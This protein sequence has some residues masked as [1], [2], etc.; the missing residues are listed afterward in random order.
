[1][2]T[3]SAIER[4]NRI[5]AQYGGDVQTTAGANSSRPSAIPNTQSRTAQ[6]A[7]PVTQ[8]ITQSSTPRAATQTALARAEAIY[9]RYGERAAAARQQPVTNHSLQSSGA[10]DRGLTG[11]GSNTAAGTSRYLNS[12][13]DKAD[14]RAS[15]LPGSSYAEIL[16]RPDYAANSAAG[17][18]KVRWGFGSD[19]RYDY[20]NDIDGRRE[21]EDYAMVRAMG[22]GE[23]GKYAFMTQDE[24]G[25]YN[26]LYAT[27]GKQ[28]ANA[29]L[30]ELEPELNRQ[31]YSGASANAQELANENAA[32]KALYSG[33]TVLGQPARSLSSMLAAGQD[34]MNTI[35]GRGIDPYSKLR[36]PS[37]LTQD[38]REGIS[39]GMGKVESFLYNTGMSA[40]DSAMNY[41]ASRGLGKVFGLTGD[42]LM[43]ATNIIGSALMSSEVASTSVTE[44]KNKGYS[45]AG[46]LSLGLIRG[47]IEYLSEAIGGEWV[48]KN[49]KSNPLNLFSTMLLGMIPEGMEEVMSDAGNEA[50]NIIIDLLF[51]TDESYIANSL[52]YFTEQGDKDPVGSTLK[53]IVQHELLS[54]LGGA[55]A[56]VGSSGVQYGTNRAAINQ[57]AEQLHTTPET[58]VTLMQEL[59]TDNPQLIG[60]LAEMHDAENAEDFRKKVGEAKN[61]EEAIDAAMK[62]KGS[63]SAFDENVTDAELTQ[64]R[65]LAGQALNTLNLDEQTRA[66]LRVLQTAA[67]AELR[68]RGAN[69]KNAA[70]DNG[71]EQRAAEGVGPYANNTANNANNTANNANNITGRGAA[72]NM[73]GGENHVQ[74]EAETEGVLGQAQT[75]PPT[76]EEAGRGGAP[77]AAAAGS[78][79]GIETAQSGGAG[80]EAARPAGDRAGWERVSDAGGGRDAGESSGGE[81]GS[82]AERTGRHRERETM[83]RERAAAIRR[84]GNALRARGEARVVSSR[85]LGIANGTD[86]QDLTVIDEAHYNERLRKLDEQVRRESGYDDVV[87]VI[88][89]IHTVNGGKARGAITGSRIIIQLDHSRVPAENI[90]EHEVFHAKAR[91]DPGLVEAARQ[92]IIERFTPEEF[93]R[94]LDSYID[95]L[96]GSVLDFDESTDPEHIQELAELVIEE[97]TADAYADINYFGLGADRYG[98]DVRKTVE[99]RAA[100]QEQNRGGK[101]ETRGPPTVQHNVNNDFGNDNTKFSD[102]DTE[103]DLVPWDTSPLPPLPGANYK[104]ETATPDRLA[105]DQS[106]NVALTAS[107]DSINANS[108]DGNTKFSTDDSASEG[109]E[110]GDN[111][112]SDRELLLTAASRENAGQDLTAYARKNGRIETLE[113]KLTRLQEAMESADEEE[114]PQLEAMAAKAEK[115]LNRAKDDLAKM[116][117]N[118]VLKQTLDRERTAWREENPT[119]AARA[120]RTLREENAAM[121]ELVDYWKGQAKRTSDSDR[122]VMPEDTRRMARNLLREHSSE[123]STE[124]I[125]GKLQQLGNY[126]VSADNLDFNTIQKEARGIAREIVDNAYA[127]V[128][129]NADTREQ[130]RD[131]LRSTRLKIS[132][133][134]RGDV[135]D[136]ADFRRRNMGTLRLANEGRDIDSAYEELSGMFG[137][138]FFPKSITAH[139]DQLNQILDV[140]D[141]VQPSYEYM[142]SRY[143]RDEVIEHVTNEI[144]DGLIS[145]DVRQSK[146]YADRRYEHMARRNADLGERNQELNDR[147]RDER[148]NRRQL[149]QEKV[150]ELRQRSVDRDKSYRKR[151]AINKTVQRLSKFLTENSAKNHVPDNMKSM[152]GNLLLSIDTLSQRS[153]E[154]AQR[155]YL[156]RMNDVARVVAN[157]QKYMNGGEM[158][159]SMFL[160]LPH[161]LGDILSEHMT[162]IQDA[163]ENDRTWTTARMDLQ[164]LE[165]LDTI[166]NAVSK[167]VTTANELMASANNAKVSE[168]SEKTIAHLDDLG[169]AKTDN[170]A[171]RFLQFQNTTPYYFFK[172]FGEGGQL[173]FK[174]LQEG[175][176]KLGFNSKEVIDYAEKAYTGEECKKAESD[177]QEFKLHTRTLEEDGTENLRSEEAQTVRLTKAQIMELYTLSKRQQALGH[178]LGAGIRIGDIKDANGK[179][180]HQADNYLLTMEDLAAITGTLSTREK[181]IADT[182]QKHMNTKGSDWGNEVSMARFGVRQFTEENYW[183]IKTDSRSRAVRD[184]GADATNLFR[185]LNMSFTKSTVRDARNAVVIGSAFDTYA[186]HMADMAKYNALGLPMLDAMKWF[187][188]NTATDPNSQGQYTTTSVQKSTERAYGT[189]AQ[190]YF[191][192]FMK[193]MNG[194][195]EG[196]RDLEQFGSKMLSNYKVAAVGANLR[197]AMLQPTAY[198]RATAVLDPKYLVRGLAHNKQGRK[199]AMKYSGTAVWKDLGFYDTNI[200]NGLRAMI[201]HSDSAFEQIRE[202]SMILAKLGDKTTWGAIWNACK[203]QV[204]ETQHLEGEVLMKATAEL[205]DEVIY[206]TQVMDS[207]MTRSHSMRQ[208]GVYAGMTTAFMSEPTLSYNMVL[209]AYNEYQQE[210][211]KTGDVGKALNNAGSKLA[212]TMAVYAAT[213]AAASIVES[214]MDAWRDDDKYQ[215]RV[216]KWLE[217]EFG[218]GNLLDG[219]LM[220]DLLIHN[221]LPFIKEFDSLIN[222]Y[223][224]SRMDTEWMSNIVKT[225][226]I[227]RETLQLATGKLDKPTDITY[228]GKMTPWG[229]LY[230]TLK[231]A[232]Q[233]AGLPVGNAGREIVALYNN[234]IGMATGN[235]IS[236]YNP[237]AKNEVKY[238]VLDGWLSAEEAQRILTEEG[239]LE[240]E[241]KAETEVIK[242]T[243]QSRSE[244][245]TSTRAKAVQALTNSGA[246]STQEA[247]TTT[248]EIWDRIAALQPL[249]G[250][251]SVTKT[252]K[253]QTIAD[254]DI[255]VEQQLTMLG[256]LMEEDELLK[257]RTA[258]DY[259]VTPKVYFDAKVAMYNVSSDG[260][261]S[262][263]EAKQALDGQ[264]SLSN[265]ERAVIWQ[266]QN[267]TFKPKDNPYDTAIGSQVYDIITGKA[268]SK[269]GLELGS[270]GSGSSGAEAQS[271]AAA[272]NGLTLG[273][274]GQY[275]T[276]APAQDNNVAVN[277]GLT[278]GSW[279]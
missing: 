110:D 35:T 53:A 42:A 74:A 31:W 275:S 38:V 93:R 70:H 94:M 122:T 99:E 226:Q 90:A 87:F 105:N 168:V 98:E 17:D 279:G 39:K 262:K 112:P 229:K 236:T 156:R 106:L 79:T 173:I 11:T 166:L 274:W 25:V 119:E 182:L 264:R 137:E 144:I 36:Q 117:S 58:V 244:S 228:Y 142:Y 255:P 203:N 224:N 191:I 91:T 37:L 254:S 195:H 44:S 185:L 59:D 180:I 68:D 41:L 269:G 6:A 43:K 15:S 127:L 78:T 5:A 8:P 109:N 258:Y 13:Y 164:Q 207:T 21:K 196:G 118:P 64:L 77:D 260:Q 243:A 216:Q 76:G 167:A 209:D 242:W 138:G 199:E 103:N 129:E 176:G 194:T 214:L 218:D 200:N 276:G 63:R 108:E 100:L 257:T 149:V 278:L 130:L 261:I 179:T 66:Q 170:K 16:T 273:S 146:T 82:L 153:G 188:Y 89:A 20:I 141:H 123:A 135:T 131:Y 145:G 197:V 30:E 183:P 154:K 270:W 111:V 80:I 272:H 60:W 113:R 204:S 71:S 84:Y 157:Q 193:D 22:N 48:I 143:E 161:E 92:K 115:Q 251:A 121:R 34:L 239:I 177:V 55:F 205:F 51:N 151:V 215:S 72:V 136:M 3:Q 220:Q 61:A 83:Q 186:N 230:Q 73:T 27:Q 2:P 245:V 7:A 12:V 212:R 277:N 169:P 259:G 248:A 162:A 57:S 222:G 225:Y 256:A 126:L 210:L 231:T 65:D 75:V 107:D 265:K 52:Q 46:A 237:G 147:L 206:R 102:D 232:S 219:N 208:K 187:N 221:K 67:D 81:A 252:Q 23:L 47:G 9:A 192:Q 45:D 18:S 88:G 116:E 133:E 160:D 101:R 235:T 246:A 172:R 95:A 181:E 124:R 114:R 171:T 97:L 250:R 155:E 148:R 54:F 184:P 249:P 267:K 163:V 266:L 32:T 128:D 26:Y 271:S 33:L 69:H 50:A 40:G 132:D 49:V 240:D 238:A 217:A 234:T 134:L 125:A 233:M 139:A 86:A 19:T 211:R 247:F 28:A 201:K 223:S 174:N 62:V 263:A 227:W 202:K 241:A 253:Y 152:V 175:W 198:V 14:S 165:E 10:I 85:E 268:E 213:A 159:N 190:H 96:T 120:M 24:I 140:M 178:I 158:E 29:F 56:T 4:A 104:E 150:S 189:E 1:M